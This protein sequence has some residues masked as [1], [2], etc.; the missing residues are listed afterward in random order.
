MP[1]PVDKHSYAYIFGLLEATVEEYLYGGVSK[2]F[3]ERGL[4][5]AQKLAPQKLP[6]KK[7]AGGHQ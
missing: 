1:G 2:E 6:P 5:D 3:L 7:T 4:R